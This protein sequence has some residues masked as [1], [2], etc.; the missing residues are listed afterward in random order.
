MAHFNNPLDNVRIATPCNADWD[1]MIGNERT[2]FC[3]QCS[4]NVYNLSGM[5]RSEAESLIGNSEGRLCIRYYRRKDG[6]ILTQDCPV[7]LAAIR[8]RM[9]AVARAVSSA[10]LSFLAGLGVYQLINS[11]S[12]RPFQG[13]FMGAIAIQEPRVTVPPIQIIKRERPLMGQQELM[14][15]MAPVDKVNQRP[16]RR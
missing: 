13:E 1:Q 9:S 8:R 11:L 7:G 2:R 12:P 3:G 14:G 15:K 5:T 4:L 16:G 10:V 6:S